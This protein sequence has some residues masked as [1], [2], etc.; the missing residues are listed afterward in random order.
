MTKISHR[1]H[2]V[3]YEAGTGTSSRVLRKNIE[4][5]RKARPSSSKLEEKLK[6]A[7]K[8]ARSASFN[9]RFTKCNKLVST[10]RPTLR[11]S[12]KTKLVTTSRCPQATLQQQQ[13]QRRQPNQTVRQTTHQQDNP[14]AEKLIQ[15]LTWLTSI[16]QTFSRGTK[17]TRQQAAR[18]TNNHRQR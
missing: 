15:L 7:T 13:Q 5:V 16:Q 10:E 9:T 14:R 4:H 6:T 11:K 17:R 3:W 2:A 12:W 1:V 8:R 18:L